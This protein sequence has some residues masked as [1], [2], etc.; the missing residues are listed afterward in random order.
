MNNSHK[1][2]EKYLAQTKSSLF[3]LDVK[4]AKGC[5]I[6]DTTSKKY[7]DLISGISVSNLGHQ[8]PAV[9]EAIKSQIDNYMH[10]MVYGDFIQSPQVE[11]AK[12]LISVLP[13]VFEKLF[14]VNSGSEA[15][16]GAIK[17]AKKY[18]GRTEIIAFRNSYHGSTLGALSL[19]SDFNFRKNFLPLIPDV[20]ILE[21]NNVD[22]LK[23]ISSKTA[24]VVVEPI[25]TAA[26]I[27][28]AE[29][30]FLI[31]LAN[32]CKQENA[33]LIF[34]EIQTG[35]G[36]TGK[37]FAFQHYNI[38]PDI[39]VLAKSFGGGLPLGTFVSSNKIFE[40]FEN[41]HPLYG[42]ATT[43]GGNP[44]ACAAAIAVLNTIIND[45][46][47]DNALKI[48][49]I[50]IKKLSKINTIKSIRGMGLLLG[51]EFPSEKI[52]RNVQLQ[53]FEKGV[54]TNTLLFNDK[55]LQLSPPLIINDK[56]VQYFVDR[57][58]EIFYQNSIKQ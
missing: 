4:S 40:C 58:Y 2:F 6:T 13:P 5:W 47:I 49:K 25:Q 28:P 36:R 52:T 45:S 18:T 12:L 54:I 44:V 37:M 21:Y 34:D 41:S 8:H 22:D 42:H 9:I 19:L 20:R 1:D 39:L 33:L 23:Q 15:I 14:Y 31:A 10:V 3:K 17:L 43:G 16:E 53:L 32:K 11:L 57:L 29:K 24:A 55:T 46:L 50:I 51:I 35:L 30:Q 26:G 27:I 56:E 38:I 48:N 7:L